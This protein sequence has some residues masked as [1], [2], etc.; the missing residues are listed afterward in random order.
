MY[1]AEVLKVKLE[2]KRFLVSEAD[3][4]L[5]KYVAVNPTKLI[6]LVY[7]QCTTFYCGDD[8]NPEVFVPPKK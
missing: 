8:I 1:V 3:K 6:L 2:K 5:I 7:I 4:Y